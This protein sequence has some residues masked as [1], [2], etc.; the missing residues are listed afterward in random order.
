MFHEFQHILFMPLLA[1]D[2]GDLLIEAPDDPEIY[3]L[4]RY[5][6]SSPS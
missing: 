4:T 1:Q 3:S 5:T 2:T 6:S